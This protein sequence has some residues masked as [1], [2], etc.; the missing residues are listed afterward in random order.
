M[1]LP[2]LLSKQVCSLSNNLYILDNSIIPHIIMQ[3]ALNRDA[4]HIALY[5]LNSL[6]DM[7]QPFPIALSLS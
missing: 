6:F 4:I 3:Q 7:N 2:K 5:P 1:P